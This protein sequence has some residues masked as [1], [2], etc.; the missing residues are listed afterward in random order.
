MKFGDFVSTKEIM[1]GIALGFKPDMAEVMNIENWEHHQVN[2]NDV[3]SGIGK[4]PSIF[5]VWR[6]GDFILLPDLSAYHVDDIASVIYK[7]FEQS[8]RIYDFNGN[9]SDFNIK[10]LSNRIIAGIVRTICKL[11]GGEDV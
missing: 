9:H 7:P 5:P 1:V 4:E 3:F 11:Q 8:I 10:G 6:V 2:K